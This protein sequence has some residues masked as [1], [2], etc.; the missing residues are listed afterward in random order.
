MADIQII[1]IGLKARVHFVS[2][3]ARR[4]AERNMEKSARDKYW[5]DYDLM[6]D[7]RDHFEDVGFNVYCNW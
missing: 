5:I 2:P 3:E 7:L 6:R 1:R 4:W